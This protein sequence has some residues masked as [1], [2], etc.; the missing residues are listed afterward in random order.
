MSEGAPPWRL[1]SLLLPVRPAL[2]PSPCRQ[3]QSSCAA[4]C[5]LPTSC[6]ASAPAREGPQQYSPI[7]TARLTH[8]HHFL[9]SVQFYTGAQSLLPVRY[10]FGGYN[11]CYL[12][13]NKAQGLKLENTLVVFLFF[14]RPPAAWGSHRH[15]PQ[16]RTAASRTTG[17]GILPPASNARK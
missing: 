5:P 4:V 6:P 2:S 14:N 1:R 8:L 15:S 17:R 16:T 13:L 7:T 10:D 9:P 3:L 11:C 12:S